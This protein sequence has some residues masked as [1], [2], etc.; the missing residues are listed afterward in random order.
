MKRKVQDIHVDK[1]LL[2][3]RSVLL[4]GEI[5]TPM[6]NQI[7]SK[8]VALDS[9]NTRPITMYINSPGGCV[10]DGLAIADTMKGIQSQ[11][12]TMV[13]G[14]ACSMASVISTCGDK[15]YVL[16]HAIWMMH[17]MSV[18]AGDY[19]A[20]TR[21]REKSWQHYYNT[22]IN[23]LKKY[24]KLSQAE[25]DLAERGEL[26]LNAEECVKKGVADKIINSI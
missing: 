19:Y 4:F 1:I 6:A 18:Y 5:D 10:A 23:I 2:N 17:D 8:L 24:T 13:M 9:L 12:I 14:E 11:V 15:R 25:F 22:L 26:W 21:A 20:K 3:V 16:P 7:I